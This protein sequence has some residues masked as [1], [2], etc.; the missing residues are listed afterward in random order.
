[1]ALSRYASHLIVTEKGYSKYQIDKLCEEG[2]EVEF[3][4]AARMRGYYT[5]EEA[6]KMIES[7]TSVVSKDIVNYTIALHSDDKDY[8]MINVEDIIKEQNE[9]KYQLEQ[10]NEKK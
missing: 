3:T 10:K 9:E 5:I 8:E 1:M 2:K 4:A 7:G 6:A